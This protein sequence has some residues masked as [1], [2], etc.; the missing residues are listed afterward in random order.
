MFEVKK[1]YTKNPEAN[2]IHA[3]IG[4]VMELHINP[5]VRGDILVFL[6]VRVT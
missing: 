3:A 5:L 4:K 1:Y 2:Y 6:T